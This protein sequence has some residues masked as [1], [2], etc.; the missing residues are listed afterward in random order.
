MEF[1][2]KIE[3]GA[4]APKSWCCVLGLYLFD[5]LDGFILAAT[6]YKT[7]V[8][9]RGL[10]HTLLYSSQLVFQLSLS[11]LVGVSTFPTAPLLTG[12][13]VCVHCMMLI[14]SRGNVTNAL[15]CLS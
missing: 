9:V 15:G 10:M 6:W 12:V 2:Q 3:I 14:C 7:V 11:G 5:I 13:M 4:L 8:I 1:P